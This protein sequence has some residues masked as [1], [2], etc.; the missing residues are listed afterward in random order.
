[1]SE[2]SALPL[3]FAVGGRMLI[4][5]LCHPP[6]CELV[7]IGLAAS[8]N[9]KRPQPN[10]RP[11]Q[12]KQS[13]STLIFGPSYSASRRAEHF[14]LTSI[15]NYSCRVIFWTRPASAVTLQG[16]TTTARPINAI[17]SALGLRRSHQ[18]MDGLFRRSSSAVATSREGRRQ[19]RSGRAV[20]HRLR[21]GRSD[22]SGHR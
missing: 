13:G 17:R 8:A 14:L 3:C 15:V 5:S 9:G 21:G 16:P 20:Q 22:S 12:V 4:L 2:N 7:H 10:G 6:K 11:G 18:L 1:M 19:Q